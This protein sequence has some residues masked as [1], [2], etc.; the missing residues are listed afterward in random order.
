MGKKRKSKG[1]RSFVK[2]IL[3]VAILILIGFIAF[4][5]YLNTESKALNPGN[6]K[7]VNIVIPSGSGTEDIANILE[8]NKIIDNVTVF[9]L[10]SKTK[11][12]E[13]RYKAGEYVLSSNMSMIEI[14]DSLVKGNT[15]TM[16]FTIPEGY[17]LND[18]E[19]RLAEKGMINNETFKNEIETGIFDYKFLKDA[20]VGE[21]RLEGYLYPE[22]YDVF[23]SATEH[24]I[25]DRMLKQFDSLFTEEYYNRA[26]EIGLNINEVITIASL[27]E[28]ETRVTGEK[29][30]ISSVIKNR[31]EIGMPLQ[32]DATVQ[33]ALGEHK[34]RLTYA[35]LKVES[36]Y[37]TYKIN[38]IPPGPICC[39]SIDSIKAA[40]YP[41]DTD[42]LYYV[43]KPSLDGTHAFS[44]N[45]NQ[46]L[47]DKDDYIKNAFKE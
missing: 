3:T 30:I 4:T 34:E 36:P 32:I 8:E 47:K 19:N 29:E 35:D 15:N 13:G 6:N 5:V 1:G 43:L 9:K 14:M 39:P 26:E 23:T 22:T 25:I 41:A 44:N 7:A 27:I 33:Y 2:F 42:Y 37:N 28:R 38:G 20:P 16:R 24:D 40:L 10:Q 31:L 12:Y 11:G 21:N 18:I 46:F 45:Y 17:T